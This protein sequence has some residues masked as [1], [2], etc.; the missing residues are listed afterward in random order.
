[1]V[2]MEKRCIPCGDDRRWANCRTVLQRGLLHNRDAPALLQAWGL[3]EMQVRGHGVGPGAGRQPG[4]FS[5][6]G[7]WL[8]RCSH[9]KPSCAAAS[10]P[11]LPVQRGNLLGA[12][13]LLDRSA[14]LEPRN[15][16]VLRWKPVVEA[17]QTVGARRGPKAP[18]DSN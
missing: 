14:A 13:L 7:T 4:C 5:L 12:I 9:A 18:P 11:A 15:R 2:Q 10:A 8:P 17:R 3:M 16:P 6:R 1:M